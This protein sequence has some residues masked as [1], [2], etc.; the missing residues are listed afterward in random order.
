MRMMGLRGK[1]I[2]NSVQPKVAGCLEKDKESEQNQTT[3]SSTHTHESSQTNYLLEVSDTELCI[4][5]WTPCRGMVYMQN[6]KSD[7]PFQATSH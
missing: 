4:S 1:L 5:G 7:P 3:P 6:C 2:R